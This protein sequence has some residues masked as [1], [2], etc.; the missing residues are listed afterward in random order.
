[1]ADRV[2]PGPLDGSESVR[3]AVCVHTRK[4]FDSCRDKDCMEDLRLYPESA[5]QAAIANAIGVRARSAEL[6]YAGVNVEEVAFNRGYYTVD[7]RFFYRIKGEAYTL[8]SGTESI[9][10]LCVFDKR[11]L[12]FG[13]EG[14]A[15]VFTSRA[16]PALERTDL[17]TAV[18]EAVDP[19]VLNIRAVDLAE[20]LSP[21]EQELG[22]IPAF[23]SA[24]F[25]EGIALNRSPRRVYVTLGQFS[26]I[27][28]ERDTQLLMPAYDYCMPE[29]ECTAGTEDDPCALFRRISFPV[30]E[31]FPP[32]TVESC[33]SYREAAALGTQ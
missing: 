18:V 11:V 25:P 24:A 30:D 27:R 19:I 31:F 17:P 14:S 32:D 4:I 15:K 3:E 26:I 12:L 1:M 6:L 20:D 22:E 21:G 16:A 10:G 28:L 7:V 5:S 33:E 2:T 8:G 23:I 13:S 9:S 29:K